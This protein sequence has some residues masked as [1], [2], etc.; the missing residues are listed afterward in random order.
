[1][2]TSCAPSHKTTAYQTSG[3]LVDPRSRE[4]QFIVFRY[5]V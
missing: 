1:M 3:V 4:N 2:Q 5:H